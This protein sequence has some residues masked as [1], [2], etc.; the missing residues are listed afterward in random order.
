MTTF[1]T[2][3]ATPD[4][5]PALTPRGRGVIRTVLVIAAV[6]LC[7]GAVGSVTAVAV[8][9]GRTAVI[10]DSAELPATMRALTVSTADVPMAV[11]ITSDPQARTPRAELRF[12]ST[13]GSGQRLDVTSTP[14]GTRLAVRGQTPGWMQWAR[15]GR[16]DV[17]LPPALARQLALTTSQQF[18]MLMVET[19]LDS[20]VARTDNGAV[21]LGGSA[22]T[23][24]I[25]NQHGSVHSRDPILV[26]ESF[27]A[28]SVDGD[29]TVDFRDAAP[30]RIQVSSGDG[31]VSIELPG[32]GPFVVNASTG[33]AGGDT[34]VRVPQT[35]DPARAASV[36]TVRSE[37]GD[38]TVR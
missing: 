26:R 14:D 35:F 15:A 28:N 8:G 20:V 1:Q 6:L 31:D 21:L 5:P 3:P 7:L 37:T 19:D 2:P 13:V 27:S 30:R 4:A 11:R 10:A 9:V 24:E 23:I 16:L 18:G 12:F 33:S 34:V 25:R 36:V 38:V 22:R 17:V 29:V 32:A